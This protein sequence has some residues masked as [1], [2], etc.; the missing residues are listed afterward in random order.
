M[1]VKTW[2]YHNFQFSYLAPKTESTLTGKKRFHTSKESKENITEKYDVQYTLYVD[3]IHKQSSNGNKKEVIITKASS[4]STAGS[5]A[6]ILTKFIRDVKSTKS[7]T[8]PQVAG[9]NIGRECVLN[10]VCT[11]LL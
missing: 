8:R 3:L 1:Y 10:G 7:N 11:H 5:M 2:L 9:K 6:D 4:L